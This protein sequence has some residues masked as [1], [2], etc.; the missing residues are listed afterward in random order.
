MISA[1]HASTWSAISSDHT[2]CDQPPHGCCR[3]TAVT[4]S[5]R[6]PVSIDRVS[7]IL[8]DTVGID[9]YSIPVSFK[10]LS[11]VTLDWPS[12]NTNQYNAHCMK[13]STTLLNHNSLFPYES[14]VPPS[15]SSLPSSCS[16]SVPVVDISYAFSTLVL[17]TFVFSVSLHIPSSGWSDLLEFWSLILWQSLA[18][19]ELVSAADYTTIRG[20]K[21]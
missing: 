18:A 2:D 11:F 14:S 17:K 20:T 7:I 4:S 12:S 16:D 9:R 3:L 1:L 13:I 6:K 8:L 10:A 5:R 15:P 19:V 21:I